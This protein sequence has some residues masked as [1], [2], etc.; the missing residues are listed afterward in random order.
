MANVEY[1]A[2]IKEVVNS[3]T[4]QKVFEEKA[5]SMGITDTKSLLDTVCAL[6][7]NIDKSS[8][9]QPSNFEYIKETIL[10]LIVYSYFG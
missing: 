2:K 6:I 3:D 10:P 9:L 8:S 1:L 7:E 5:K 4:V